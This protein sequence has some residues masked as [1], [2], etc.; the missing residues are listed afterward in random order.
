MMIL[1]SDFDSDPQ[2]GWAQSQLDD[3]SVPPP[4]RI[5]VLFG[6]TVEYLDQV[7]GGSGGH[8]VRALLRIRGYDFEAPLD[9]TGAGLVSGLA[10]LMEQFYPEKAA[11]QGADV[12]RALVQS[13]VTRAADHG[14]HGPNGIAV[15]AT[16]AF[17]LGAGFDTDPIYWWAGDSL[18]DAEALDEGVRVARLQAHAREFLEAALREGGGHAQQE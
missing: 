11:Y 5:R 17:M 18:A 3:F 4:E 13:A 2:F 15:Y 12:N 14:I 1:G 8:I 10:S 16:L 6:S 7:A 9:S